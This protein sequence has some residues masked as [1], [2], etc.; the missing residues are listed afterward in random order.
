MNGTPALR[1]SSVAPRPT[2]PNPQN[3]EV[4]F[5]AFNHSFLPPPSEVAVELQFDDRLRHDTDGGQQCGNA[6]RIR[7]T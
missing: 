5:Q 3:Y 4:I 6:E 1:N 2:R 7:K